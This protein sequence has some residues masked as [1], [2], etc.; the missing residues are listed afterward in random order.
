MS[1]KLGSPLTQ[2]NGEKY[3]FTF[4]ISFIIFAVMVIPL[5][6][7]TKGYLIYY[8][9]YNS[10]QI[11]FYM[12]AHDVI[13]SGE[14][15]W[16]WGTDLGTNFLGSYS[17]YLFGSPFFWLTIPFPREVVPF[18]MAPLLCLKY[19]IA[20]TTAYAYIRKF[21]RNK[22]LA[23]VDG[24]LYAFSGFQAYNIFF[25]HFHDVTA[26]FPLLLLAVEE[27][28]NNNRRGVFALTVALMSVINYF[29]FTG[30]VVFVILY[31]ICRCF[32]EDFEITVKKFFGLAVEAVIGVGIACFILL[33]SALTVMGNYRVNE[34]LYGLDL[35]AYNDKTRI[36]RIIQSF[37]M[38]PDVPARTNLF[39]SENAK[40]ASIGG[41]LPL[42][43]MAGVL[44]FAR[45]R[46]KH[47]AIK[48]VAICAVCAFVPVLNS[49]F[50]MLNA[51]YYAR[52][53][54]MPVL[55][56]AMMTAQTL[57]NR[58]LDFDFG[59]KICSAF[60]LLMGFFAILP[61]K[62]EQTFSDGS[63]K[64][65]IEWFNLPNDVPYFWGV[66]LISMT[67][68]ILVAYLNLC[69]K[70]GKPFIKKSLVLTIASCFIC[71][72]CVFY[73]GVAIDGGQKF[74]IEHGIKGSENIS[75]P[76]SD[77][78]YRIDTSKNYDNFP[79]MWNY[80]TMRTF[81]S[82]VPASIMEFYPEVGVQRD[83]ASRADTDH[84]TLRSLF[85]VKYYF[86][87][88]NEN[89]TS[90]DSIMT[91]FKYLYT[92]NGFDIYENQLYI[93]LGFGYNQYV[94]ESDLEERS[95]S[96]KE[97]LL[98][99]AIVLSDEQIEKYSSILTPFDFSESSGTSEMQYSLA[100]TERRKNASSKFEYS[101]S[102]FT[103]EITLTSDQLVFFSVPYED[104]W[105]ATVNGQPAE[106]EKVSYG[107]MAV[108]ADAGD[109][110]IKFSYETPGLKTGF[111]ISLGSLLLLGI[112]MLIT[113]IMRKKIAVSYDYYDDMKHN[114]TFPKSKSYDYDGENTSMAQDYYESRV[115][116]EV[117]NMDNGLNFDPPTR[118]KTIVNEESGI[119]IGINTDE[120]LKNPDDTDKTNE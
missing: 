44:S 21:V 66:L 24:L 105:T 86:D 62:V 106:I 114:E 23:V 35:V 78:F 45:G 63:K 30:Q 11:P 110:V 17:F 83:V 13:R 80:S 39:S 32:S 76:V 103:S 22:N 7:Y 51:S 9:D 1:K 120:F 48:L 58:E 55:I 64:D 43:S 37:F 93:P 28:I 71:T 53:F 61:R 15:M 96:D 42:F 69:R 82:V 67:G 91:G 75:L 12:H 2:K 104:G 49:S 50:Y 99:S 102:G 70:K 74:Y 89:V 38:I 90:H 33:P 60:M 56:M 68:I 46:K 20:S 95:D 108:K 88:S 4:V 10:Q 19:A 85:S 3:L 65:V 5:L 79:M 31:F 59:I 25:N 116:S 27:R 18:L 40:W 72:S 52:W 47:W 81:H 14:F 118:Q 16:D 57:D 115:A 29:F 73:Y 6:I 112:Y 92:Q 41:Y 107:F 77:T 100:C 97:K 117:R 84:Y 54:Y 119:D 98:I 109:N 8:G 113:Q 34:R 87:K 111:I 26:F 36:W 94:S 101:G